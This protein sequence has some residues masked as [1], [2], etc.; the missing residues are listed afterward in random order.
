MPGMGGIGGGI[1]IGIGGG[2][3]VGG[4]M[5]EHLARQQAMQHLQTEMYRLQM[6]LLQIQMGGSLDLV[7][8]NNPGGTGG[9][10][11]DGAQP[12]QN[13]RPGREDI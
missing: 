1:G 7:W 13:P 11:G 9:T 2:I 3:G 6:M 12:P 10:G 4:N 8:S 5:Q